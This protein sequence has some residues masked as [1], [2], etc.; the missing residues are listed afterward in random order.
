MFFLKMRPIICFGLPAL[1]ANNIWTASSASGMPRA[2]DGV[3]GII[4]ANPFYG[5]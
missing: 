1:I 5:K 4:I 2:E 3:L